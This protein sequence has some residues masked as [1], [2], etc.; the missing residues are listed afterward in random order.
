[1]TRIFGST[2]LAPYSVCTYTLGIGK[3]VSHLFNQSCLKF[4]S[5]SVRV[6]NSGTSNQ[7]LEL[8]RRTINS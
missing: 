1:M 6:L 3:L 8:A 2:I 7:V 5:T 4:F